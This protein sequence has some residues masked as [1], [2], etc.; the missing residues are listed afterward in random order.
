M[1]VCGIK[2]AWIGQSDFPLGGVNLSSG[3]REDSASAVEA[4]EDLERYRTSSS[5]SVDFEDARNSPKKR[6]S[7]PH[8]QREESWDDDLDDDQDDSA[9]FGLFAEKE[10]DRTVTARSRCAAL[11]R[12]SSTPPLPPQPPFLPLPFLMNQ[13]P[14]TASYLAQDQPF[15]KGSPTS[16]V[17]SMAN[18][19]NT[20]SSTAHLRPTSAFALLPPSPPI[21]KERERRWLRK[22]SRP[23]PQGLFEL[24]SMNGDLPSK[25]HRVSFSDG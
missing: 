3:A 24:S 16:S 12:L 22:K 21:H 1:V 20:Y 11:S 14:P 10:E 15:P 7:T 13:P 23:R 6:I 25:Q 9:K 18:T 19:V 17:F 2:L 8:R 4:L 5:Q